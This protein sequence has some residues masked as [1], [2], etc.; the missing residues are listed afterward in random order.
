M[1]SILAPDTYGSVG[2]GTV[3]RAG[4]GGV[5][6]YVGCARAVVERFRGLS[7]WLRGGGGIDGCGAGDHGNAERDNDAYEGLSTSFH[8]SLYLFFDCGKGAAYSDDVVLVH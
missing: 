8:W 6:V 4:S 7:S 2:F 1:R 5:T 3:R